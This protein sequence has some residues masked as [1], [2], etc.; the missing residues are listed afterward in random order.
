MS[1]NDFLEK[2]SDAISEK[3][4]SILT[5]VGIGL[6]VTTAV[7]SAMGTP[8]AHERMQAKRVELADKDPQRPEIER[9]QVIF[10]GAPAYVP[11]VIT[12]GLA[13]FCLVYANKV[14]ID[15]EA[16]LI[17]AYTVAD[18]SLSQYKEAIKEK[19]GDKKSEEIRD[20]VAKM[21]LRDNPVEHKEIFVLGDDQ[22]LC[23]DSQSGRYFRASVQQIREA[24]YQVNKE[25]VTGMERV[26]FL[27]TFYEAL[28]LPTDA[29]IG[30]VMG[31]DIEH[32]DRL[33]I[34]LREGEASDGTPCWVLDY[35]V[36]ALV[37]RDW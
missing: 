13:I 11:A 36:R 12:G 5:G 18:K 26:V 31:W 25:M 9:A 30:E 16:A 7:L 35:D 2:A 1:A 20:E 21:Q 17:G 29:R 32:G 15:R 14:H 19:L 3:S 8:R 10:A 24:E 6:F 4:P 37:C 27:D 34:H 23:L 33:E 22:H 28:K